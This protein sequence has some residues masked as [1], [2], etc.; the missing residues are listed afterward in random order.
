MISKRGSKF[1]AIKDTKETIKMRLSGERKLRE[2]EDTT[3]NHLTS[4]LINLVSKE[5]SFVIAHD[6]PLHRNQET[7][8]LLTTLG[9]SYIIFLFCI[10]RLYL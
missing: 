6:I 7:Q 9:L 4:E 1:P 5:S 10:S 3:G 2:R 8:D